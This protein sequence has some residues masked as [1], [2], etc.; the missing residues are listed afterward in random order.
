MRVILKYLAMITTNDGTCVRDY[1]HVTDLAQAHL[2][3]LERMAQFKGF[4][5][6]NLGNGNG[7]SVLEVIKS[8]EHATN[9]PISYDVEERR[10]GDPATLVADS[11]KARESLAWNARFGSLDVIVSTA[12]KWHKTQEG[13]T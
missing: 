3:G 12:M 5:T 6:F 7:F 2:L 8:C 11:F 10:D 9:S 1:V 4:S 13:I